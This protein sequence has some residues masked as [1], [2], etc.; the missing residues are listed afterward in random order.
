MA[1]SERVVGAQA[2]RQKLQRL[3][4]QLPRAVLNKER[5]GSFML[6]RMRQRFLAE[7]D[8][9][10][11][12]WPALKPST[13]PG[14]QILLRSGT[15]YRAIA[16]MNG[17][18]G[19]SLQSATGLGFRIGVLHHANNDAYADEYGAIHQFG[20]GITKRRFLGIGPADVKAVDALLRREIKNF[21]AR[22]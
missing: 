5:L 13:R 8:P 11:V 2:L 6:R 12:R 7:K 16:V 20:L 14:A 9:Q 22:A 21:L 19:S 18:S 10:G 1:G 4:A 3:G 15:L 17:D